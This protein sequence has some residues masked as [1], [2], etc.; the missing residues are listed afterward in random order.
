MAAN[1]R[2]S[3]QRYCSDCRVLAGVICDNE[4]LSCRRQRMYPSEWAR[5]AQLNRAAPP[6]PALYF[7]KSDSS[8][9]VAM[10]TRRLILACTMSAMLTFPG[11]VSAQESRATV[12][13]RVIDSS[14]AVV[15]GVS[16]TFTN[17]DTGVVVKTVT[18][19]EG[20]YFSSFL[21]PGNYRIVGE[22]SG[23]KNVVRSG[24]TLSVNDRLELNLMRSE[25]HTSELQSR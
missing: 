24:V 12:I 11:S 22:K 6:V 18:N 8:L 10:S 15:P 5:Y 20:N 25:E 21:I 9:E 1:G 19:N 7:C 4:E 17:V 14:G 13:G 3:D 16:L 2:S 23:F